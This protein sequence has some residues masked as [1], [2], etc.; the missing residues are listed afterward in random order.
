MTTNVYDVKASLL[1]SDS[2]WSVDGGDWIAYVDDTGYDKITFDARLAF[3]FAGD[4]AEIDYWKKWVAD[5]R[6]KNEKPLNHV[7]RISVLQVDVANG[8]VVFQRGS[9]Q[10]AYFGVSKVPLAT[11]GGSGAEPA[12]ICW[13]DN[14]CAMKAVSSAIAKDYFSGGE[15]MFYNRANHQSNVT[16]SATVADVKQQAKERGQIMNVKNGQL[17]TT[18]KDAV[19]D[20]SNPAAQALA[21]V[22]LSGGASFNAPFPDM[23]KPWTQEEI[24]AFDAALSAYDED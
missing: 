11:F 12:K 21:N 16:N 14:K 23:D 19:N 2:R 4:M 7:N 17:T 24:E 3:L 22:V 5:G 9:F 8:K 6:P 18:V 13:V 1:T 15:T 20:P 10:G